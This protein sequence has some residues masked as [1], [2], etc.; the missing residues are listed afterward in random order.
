M[1]MLRFLAMI[2]FALAV[3]AWA[4]ENTAKATLISDHAAAAPGGTVQLAVRFNIPKGWHIYGP[5]ASGD[6]GLPTTIDWVMPKGMTAG[7]IRWPAMTPFEFQGTRGLG[8]SGDVVLPMTANVPSTAKV[9]EKLRFAALVSWLI[10]AD[11]CIPEQ[12]DVMLQLPIEETARIGE[13]SALFTTTK[14]DGMALLRAALFAFLGGLILNLM[15]C[16]FPVL[17]MKALALLNKQDKDN[18]TVFIG[19]AAYLAGVLVSLA[20]MAP[21]MITLQTT[22]V[23]AGWGMQMQSPLFIG[24]M[25]GVMVLVGLFMAGHIQLRG[26]FVNWGQNLAAMH[27]HGGTFFTGVLA[28]LVA[29]PC[30]APFM[31]G[32]IFFA[33]T[34]G[35]F[36][37][38]AVFLSLGAGLAFP[39][40]LLCWVPAARRWLPRPGA[41]MVTF[42]KILAWPMYAAAVWL[43]WV[44]IQQVGW[45]P[46]GNPHRG[47]EPYS[48]TRLTE[49][50]ATKKPVF[51]NMTA[52]WCI[53]CIFNEQN[54]LR[55]DE[56]Q[57][58]MKEKNITYMVGDWTD[59][60]DAIAAFLASHSRSGVPLYVYYPPQGDAVILPQ[61]LTSEILINTFKGKGEP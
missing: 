37:T 55:R 49:L 6:I 38:L 52:T 25:A 54:V 32:A 8:Y 24:I 11:I 14:T 16:V 10:C 58:V 7:A 4:A 39:Y 43:V 57:A 44:F 36:I 19:G 48:E 5:Q 17:S 53:T 56:I 35:P 3:P 50:R 20:N 2:F 34:A 26:N 45:L 27:G 59:K 29:T 33:L 60:N 51:V 9:G 15:P 1:T 13:H 61:I 31:G 40:V 46:N 23:T 42:K 12:A 18:R 47:A 41:W 22:G 21:T 28:V 30:T